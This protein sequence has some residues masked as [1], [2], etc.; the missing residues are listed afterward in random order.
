M[1]LPL[2]LLG[3]V[4]LGV[5]QRVDHRSQLELG[6]DDVG[7]VAV[8]VDSLVA[9]VRL[10]GAVAE[11]FRHFLQL[12]SDGVKQTEAEGNEIEGTRKTLISCYLAGVDELDQVILQV[13]LDDQFAVNELLE[14]LFRQREGV[15]VQVS[16]G[17]DS[18][19]AVGLEDFLGSCSGALVGLTWSLESRTL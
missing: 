2:N 16:D 4:E 12:S 5:H 10:D 15:Q 17:E 18:S 13:V 19:V 8:Q 3:L 7:L 6:V 11:L 1:V 14:L 9:V